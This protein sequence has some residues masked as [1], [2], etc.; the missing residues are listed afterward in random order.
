MDPIPVTPAIGPDE[1]RRVSF[2]AIIWALVGLSSVFMALRIWARMY[3]RI[4]GTDDWHMVA[5]WVRDAFST[6]V[7]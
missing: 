2:E 5:C 7:G 3:A 4:L 6:H 1:D